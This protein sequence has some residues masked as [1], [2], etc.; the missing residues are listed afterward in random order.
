[1]GVSEL[2]V[3]RLADYLH[4]LVLAD[5]C[6]RF[7]SELDSFVAHSFS[8]YLFSFF[9]G[10][11]ALK[12]PSSKHVPTHSLEALGIV[13]VVVVKAFQGVADDL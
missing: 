12:T 8:P 6:S 9:C 10:K 5:R 1:M 7:L 11:S 2:F 3:G 13:V 4:Q